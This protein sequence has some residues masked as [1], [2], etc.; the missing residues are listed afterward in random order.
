M[1]TKSTEPTFEERFSRPTDYFP[2]YD[3]KGNWERRACRLAVTPQ[4]EELS[5]CMHGG[6]DTAGPSVHVR[7]VADQVQV[8]C[9]TYEQSTSGCLFRQKTGCEQAQ[10]SNTQVF[11]E[12]P[13]AKKD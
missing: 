4:H 9:L 8:T 6:S 11:N 12:F 13:S 2:G 10:R 3:G 5:V 1:N 7:Q